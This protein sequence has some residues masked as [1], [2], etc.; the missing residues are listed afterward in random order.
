MKLVSERL[1]RS[2][3]HKDLKTYLAD[4]RTKVEKAPQAGAKGTPRLTWD[5]VA[6][7][8]R[9]ITGERVVRESAR[10]WALRYAVAEKV[11]QEAGVSA[12]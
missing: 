7:E 2:K 1:Q 3:L 12:A 5:D 6:F 8:L 9:S 4:A 11:Q 10:T